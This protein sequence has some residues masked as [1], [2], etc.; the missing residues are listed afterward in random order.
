VN[1]ANKILIADPVDDAC[2]EI[3]TNEGFTVDKKTGLKEEQIMEIIGD[4]QVLIVRSSTQVTDKIIDHGENLKLIGRAGTGVDNINVDA[5]TRKGVIV[6]NTPGGNTVSTAEHAISMLMSLARN[7]PQACSSLR[8]GVWDRKTYQGVE[9]FGKTIGIIGIG[10]VGKEVA[11]RLQG[12]GMNILGSDPLVSDDVIGTLGIESVT[13]DELF[14]RSDYITIHTPLTD[15]TRGL[16]NTETIQKC[17]RGVRI[18]NCARGGIVDET[19]ILEALGTGHVGGVA[20]DVF[21]QEPPPKDFPLLRHPK[22]VVTPHLG[23]STVEAQQKVAVQIAHQIADALKER[24]L[25]GAVNI[26][27]AQF[28]VRDDHKPYLILSERLGS[29]AGQIMEGKLKSVTFA[30]DGESLHSSFDVLKSAVLRGVLSP[31]LDQ[32]VNEVNALYYARAMGISLIDRKG[33]STGNYPQKITVEYQTDKEKRKLSGTVFGAEAIRL[34]QVD[35][36]RVE[37][38]PTGSMLFYWNIDRP[39][40]LAAVGTILAKSNINIATL[41]LGRKAIGEEALTIIGLDNDIPVETLGEIAKIDGVI[42][43]KLVKV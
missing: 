33:S 15:D 42:N 39:G 11:V 20:L 35:E 26:S 40:M 28:S 6:M 13:L 10:K 31:H 18:V 25:V 34:V 29:I 4:Y 24:S 9:L 3:L 43:P 41:S 8:D 30:I 23:A 14:R 12:F 5:A 22:V 21:E 37:I 16:L 38:E 2:V 7:I 32:P 27:A 1:T 19:A 36:Y 17:K